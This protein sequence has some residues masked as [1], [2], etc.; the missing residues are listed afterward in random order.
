MGRS[1]NNRIISLLVLTLSLQGCLVAAVPLILAANMAVAGFVVFKTVQTVTGGSVSISFSEAETSPEER[2]ALSRIMSPAIW[3]G[4]E[5]EVYMASTMELSG[6]FSSVIT[7]SITTQILADENIGQ[8]INLMTA[9]EQLRIFRRVCE[10]SGADGI[11][12]FKDLG[13]ESQGNFFSLTRSN[14]IHSA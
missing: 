7:P 10:V 9:T 13:S 3:P 12:A 11:V 6:E 8:S 14:T 1:K 5:T 2:L 4:N